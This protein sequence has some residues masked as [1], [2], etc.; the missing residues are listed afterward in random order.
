[1]P[2]L[3]ENYKVPHFDGKGEA[4]AIFADLGV[5]TTNL[6]TSFYWENLIYFGSGPQRGEDGALTLN[7]PLGDRKMPS[8]A[9]DDIGRAAYA[10]FKAGP[11]YV[12]KTIGIAGEHLTGPEMAS[13]LSDALGEPVQYN[14]V[15]FDVYRGLGFPGADDLGNMFQFKHDFEEYFCGVRPIEATRA[16]NPKL[17]TFESWLAANKDRIPLDP[18]QAS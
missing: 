12:G 7:L 15:P 9:V 3:M 18:A 11:E 2:T 13:A 10:I 16:L 5:P 1:M 4:D 6:L 8:I 17:E 14:A